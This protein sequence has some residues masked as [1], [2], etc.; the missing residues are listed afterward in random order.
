M[1]SYNIFSV[2]YEP[3]QKLRVRLWSCKT[4][5]GFKPASNFVLLVVPRRYFCGGS[6]YF[7]SWCFKKNVLLAPCVYFHILVV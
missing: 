6:F 5:V 2:Y 3:L 4:G 7:M 1:A